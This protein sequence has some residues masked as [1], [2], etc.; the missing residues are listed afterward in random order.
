MD[1][2][3]DLEKLA[4]LKEKW[5]L[6]DEEFQIEKWR[7]LSWADSVNKNKLWEQFSNTHKHQEID[8]EVIQAEKEMK[9][10][11]FVAPFV[12]LLVGKYLVKLFD[13]GIIKFLED[14]GTNKIS[15]RNPNFLLSPFPWWAMEIA[16]FIWEAMWWAIFLWLIWLL[17]YFA[18]KN[19]GNNWL[20]KEL[21]K[22]KIINRIAISWILIV[23]FSLLAVF[24]SSNKDNESIQTQK[25]NTNETVDVNEELEKIDRA[26]KYNEKWLELRE[27]WKYEE[28]LKNFNEAI[29]LS[30]NMN[31]AYLYNRCLVFI[32]INE[33][34]KAIVDCKE[35]YSLDKTIAKA[36]SQLWLIYLMKWDY[37]NA[38][39][40]SQEVMTIEDTNKQSIFVNAISQYVTISSEEEKKNLLT[41]TGEKLWQEIYSEDLLFWHVYIQ[42]LDWINTGKLWEG[43]IDEWEKLANNIINIANLNSHFGSTKVS[44]ADKL[45][46]ER[47]QAYWMTMLLWL[48][49]ITQKQL[50]EKYSTLKMPENGYDYEK[51][52]GFFVDRIKLIA[53]F[54]D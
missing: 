23:I 43:N 16:W 28:A 5:I 10:Y 1:T 44:N 27:E 54:L 40:Y 32:N 52:V 50:V 11:F 24:N 29:L 53:W 7:I 51:D 9:K 31:P 17:I 12:I 37:D 21:Q 47:I 39:K 42:W 41:E 35:A 48:K 3:N 19:T 18:I 26:D 4:Q 36:P 34:E 2:I 15:L 38:K 46:Y 8:P 25:N 20:S 22:E 14:V 13:G 33:N 49:K 45:I 30:N 6:N